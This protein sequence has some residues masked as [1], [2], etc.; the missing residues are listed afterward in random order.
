MQS[1]NHLPV[2][3]SNEAIC[4]YAYNMLMQGEIPPASG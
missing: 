1:F 3:A 2:L 4:G